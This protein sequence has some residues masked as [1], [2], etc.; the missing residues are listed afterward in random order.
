MAI[1]LS[2][3]QDAFTLFLN[4]LQEVQNI[5]DFTKSSWEKTCEVIASIIDDHVKE[6]EEE[7]ISLETEGK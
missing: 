3:L 6:L 1:F 2:I 5:D 4:Y 7:K